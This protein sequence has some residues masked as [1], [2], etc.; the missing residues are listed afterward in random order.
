T[1]TYNVIDGLGGS[2]A[3]TVTITINGQNDA[4][5]ISAAVTTTVSEDDANFNLNLL[6]NA[7]DVDDG[8]VLDVSSLVNTLGDDGGISVNANGTSLDVDLSYYQYLSG[9]DTEVITYTY[10]VIDG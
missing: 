10:N 4:P 3:Q 2:V 9:S 1:Y 7:S 8:A 6:T 5:T